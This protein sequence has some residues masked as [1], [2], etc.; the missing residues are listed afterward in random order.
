[1]QQKRGVITGLV[2]AATAWL[3]ATAGGLGLT[4]EGHAAGL[5]PP[6]G[7]SQRADVA[8]SASAGGTTVQDLA[9]GAPCD[10]QKATPDQDPAS[11]TNMTT[12]SSSSDGTAQEASFHLCGGPD[13][14]AE[15]A[16]E[17]LIA[18][19]SFSATL[20]SRPDGCA[21][22]TL[23]VTSSAPNSSAR[24]SATM[25]VSTGSGRISVRIISEQGTT[26]VSIGA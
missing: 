3:L 4:L 7:S 6:G 15:R 11:G 24:Q 2:V 1:M 14:Q 5:L 20:I 22:L 17:Q 12:L 18:G 21:D 25:T 10:T 23:R 16:I 13:P 26:R 8:R 9:G 19:R